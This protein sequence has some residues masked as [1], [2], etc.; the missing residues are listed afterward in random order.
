MT[1]TDRFEAQTLAIAGILQATFLADHI[2]RT[3][4]AEPAA[5]NGI[6]HSLFAFDPD[7]ITIKHATHE[8]SRL[9]KVG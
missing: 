9:P 4:Q 6:V 1:P 7:E 8:I 2:A 3:G 5:F